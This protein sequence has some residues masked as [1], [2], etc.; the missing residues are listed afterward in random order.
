MACRAKLGKGYFGREPC[1][2]GDVKDAHARRDVS[3]AQQEGY[4][5]RRDVPEAAIVPRRCFIL[6]GQIL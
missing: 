1:A 2:R 6:V 3:G 5:V 4:E